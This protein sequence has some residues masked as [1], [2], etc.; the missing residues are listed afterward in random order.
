MDEGNK[1]SLE[2]AT[3]T[4][5]ERKQDKKK[6]DTKLTPDKTSN[7]EIG[8]LQTN[9]DNHKDQPKHGS[10][11]W[12][13]ALNRCNVKSA[14]ARGEQKCNECK[15]EAHSECTKVIFAASASKKQTVL[16]FACYD[17]SFPPI[18][19]NNDSFHETTDILSVSVD[20]NDMD[21][22]AITHEGTNGDADTEEANIRLGWTL[23]EEDK[24]DLIELIS[25]QKLLTRHSDDKYIQALANAAHVKMDSYSIPSLVKADMIEKI[26][27]IVTDGSFDISDST[28]NF[29]M[30]AL[31]KFSGT[32]A[33]NGRPTYSKK[34]VFVNLCIQRI[35][36]LRDYTHIELKHILDMSRLTGYFLPNQTLK[37]AAKD[38]L[39]NDS[40]KE[41]KKKSKSQDTHLIDQGS[42]EF[43]Q[44]FIAGCKAKDPPAA[45]LPPTHLS[46]D[47]CATGYL[48]K[49][50]KFQ[51][52]PMLQC[53]LCKLAVHRGCGHGEEATNSYKCNKCDPPSIDSAFAEDNI[54]QVSPS[55][56][57]NTTF[58]G[59]PISLTS[60]VRQ[61]TSNHSSNNQATPLHRNRSTGGDPRN[62]VTCRFQLRVE[63]TPDPTS[64]NIVSLL[65]RH[66]QDIIA[67]LRRSDATIQVLPWSDRG[68][69]TPLNMNSTSVLSL[70]DIQKYF[71]R[72]R[73]MP[74]GSAW[75]DMK[76][77]STRPPNDILADTGSWLNSNGHAVF[78]K[79][80][81]CES[82]QTV[83]WLL[84]SFRAID[85]KM[86]A[87]SLMRIANIEVDF[88]YSVISLDGG[89]IPLEHQVRAL[90]VV[91]EAG[92]KFDEA[93][94]ILQQVYCSASNEFPLD[95]PMRF[96]PSR[97]TGVDRLNKV[98]R[99]KQLQKDFLLCVEGKQALCWDIA[100]LDV[101]VGTLPTLRQLLLDVKS[102]TGDQS[103]NLFLSVDTSYNR[104]ELVL[105]SFLPFMETEVRAFISNMVPIMIH[106]YKDTRI[107]E[108]FIESAVERAKDSEWD[109]EKQELITKDDKYWDNF[110]EADDLA[111]FGLTSIEF[112]TESMQRI[113]RIIH[114]TT[115]N[116]SLG[117][118]TSRPRLTPTAVLP[119][120]NENLVQ[121]GP[122]AR[123]SNTITSTV[124]D[125]TKFSQ[126][127][128]SI[129][130]LTDTVGDMQNSLKTVST[131]QASID[132]LT[133]LIANQQNNSSTATTEAIL[134]NVQDGRSE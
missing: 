129:Q 68:P 50:Q 32:K 78:A 107:K 55:P 18:G 62:S 65:F 61:P 52:P 24:V 51:A 41:L 57:S 7:L 94:S 76:L 90:H 53:C 95:I 117:S 6:A 91:C 11:A 15:R 2:P 103:N 114:G 71:N 118:F 130:Q 112:T 26:T 16:C 36:E 77:Q 120:I 84:F 64:P 80:L 111:K 115:D 127:E 123:S 14:Q 87:Q 29:G 100:L 40:M 56:N 122:P 125:T 108:Y 47:W 60:P 3:P 5:E 128:Q 92:A 39:I 113:E 8:A 88:R 23:P 21:T 59:L 31:S 86:L 20:P 54:P 1:R 44:E 25:V 35:R 33:L 79:T 89:P 97:I 17:K 66:I 134:P 28:S 119:A 116:D 34:V 105:V 101:Q 81:Q 30:K 19:G 70:K 37:P 106:K 49:N 75:G 82:T 104:Q 121:R 83:G 126:M 9:L 72:I 48:C 46:D 27:K 45:A 13:A 67:E 124:T 109:E 4:P 42:V 22:S 131:L 63:I 99:C 96:V 93:K 73:A 133:A 69:Q 43:L 12:C 10:A 38:K 98:K 110:D 85:T 74:H 58:R 102:R 132:A